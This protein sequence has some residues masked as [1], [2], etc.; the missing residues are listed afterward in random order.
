MAL[1]QIQSSSVLQSSELLDHDL[2]Q[3]VT[4]FKSSFR[5]RMDLLIVM[6][7]GFA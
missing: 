5:V 6:N 2:E 4:D 7:D 1:R 3:R